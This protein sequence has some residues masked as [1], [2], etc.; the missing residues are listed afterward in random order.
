[1]DIIKRKNEVHDIKIVKDLKDKIEML[2]EIE[3][4]GT[5][6]NT[7]NVTIKKIH[8]YYNVLQFIYNDE[9]KIKAVVYFVNTSEMTKNMV[10]KKVLQKKC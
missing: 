8:E 2:K 7:T 1:M 4:G 6:K 5:F 3:K 9:E 10:I